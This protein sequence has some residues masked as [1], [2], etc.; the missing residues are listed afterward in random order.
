VKIRTLTRHWVVVF[1]SGYP[2][3]ETI[4][5]TKKSAIKKYLE[6][7][8]GYVTDWADARKEGYSAIRVNISFTPIERVNPDDQ[9]ARL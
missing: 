7:C 2:L 8:D 1:P 5:Y 4:A 9:Y 6:F 3:F